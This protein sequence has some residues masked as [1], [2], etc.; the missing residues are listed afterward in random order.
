M[1]W[2]I[3]VGSLSVGSAPIKN[4]LKHSKSMASA[5]LNVKKSVSLNAR[6][7]EE[8]EDAWTAQQMA[9]RASKR[10]TQGSI[11]VLGAMQQRVDNVV[12]SGLCKA[13]M[14]IIILLN[15]VQV[16]YESDVGAQCHVDKEQSACDQES[17]WL[18]IMNWVY[19]AIYTVE[20]SLR[21]YV[22]RMRSFRDKWIIFDTVI[23]VT[24]FLSEILG[25]TLPSTGI[26]RL[27]RL[28]RLIKALRFIKLPPELHVM[29]HGFVSAI[30]A[31][32]HGGVLVFVMF[33]LWAIVAVEILNAKMKDF[34]KLSHILQLED[35]EDWILSEIIGKKG[36]KVKSLRR[37][38]GCNIEIDSTELT[39]VASSDK[40]DNMN[41]CRAKLEQIVDT[42]RREC[43]FIDIPQ[44]HSA[45]FVGKSGAHVKEFQ[46]THS[47][48]AR[49]K[50][51]SGKLRL[52]G[53]EQAVLMAKEALLQWIAARERAHKHVTRENV[54]RIQEDK[55]PAVIGSKGSV[56][57]G[58]QTEFGCRIEI[59]RNNNTLSLRGG[60]AE[61]RE[62]AV[63]KIKAIASGESFEST[64]AQR[65]LSDDR[66]ALEKDSLAAPSEVRSCPK[67]DPEKTH[68]ISE[69]KPTDT[70]FPP[71]ATGSEK[72]D[73]SAR[74]IELSYP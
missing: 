17:G 51:I 52:S 22:H 54:I 66:P 32:S 74:K 62:A 72:T 64:L 70:E 21:C 9:E 71:L 37:E 8:S 45:A 65:N 61:Q 56:I 44:Q 63:V 59:D 47:V 3:P 73:A 38:T 43:V 68:C 27:A 36:N 55:I 14:S 26:L 1:S 53:N 31:I 11:V 25:G 57:Q 60:S 69:Y 15:S 42:A 10:R 20:L 30:K 7:V 2:S 49:F 23:V 39:V 24:G 19:L 28:A 5:S 4:V 35:S 46:E 16:V 33:T 67:N 50:G 34:K 29:I 12:E 40:E 6:V 48:E 58:L 13:F 41:K 18:L